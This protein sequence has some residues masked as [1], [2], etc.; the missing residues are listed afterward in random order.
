MPISPES[1][2]AWVAAHTPKTRYAGHHDK[3]VVGDEVDIRERLT[4]LAVLD[5]QS[6]HALLTS[7]PFRWVRDDATNHWSKEDI[8]PSQLFSELMQVPAMKKSVNSKQEW[9][10]YF[11]KLVPDKSAFA[12]QNPLVVAD[13]T[14]RVQLITIFAWVQYFTR[15]LQ[16]MQEDEEDAA[17][18][19]EV[20]LNDARGSKKKG[21][22]ATTE[23]ETTEKRK[24]DAAAAAAAAA[25]AKDAEKKRK[26]DAAAAAAAAALTA[27]ADEMK[28]HPEE[29]D[30]GEEGAGGSDEE[31]EEQELEANPLEPGRA[32]EG[33]VSEK[34]AADQLETMKALQEASQAL[35]LSHTSIAGANRDSDLQIAR[36]EKLATDVQKLGQ[37]LAAV[38]KVTQTK[39]PPVS[40]AQDLKLLQEQV[41]A[42]KKKS[43][44]L[45][46]KNAGL[47]Q[48]LLKV[49]AQLAQAVE[50]GGSHAKAMEKLQGELEAARQKCV[51]LETELNNTPTPQAAPIT[52]DW[53]K[54]V[55]V[56]EA[57]IKEHGK[58]TAGKDATI[59]GLQA[60]L[61]AVK[62]A[63]LLS[64]S[65]LDPQKQSVEESPVYR[66][67]KAEHSI[68]LAE[69]QTIGQARRLAEEEL[70]H[71]RIE[72]LR[73]Q[74]AAKVSID[75]AHRDE[76]DDDLSRAFIT[77]AV[78]T[79]APKKKQSAEAAKELFRHLDL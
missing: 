51:T 12:R 64:Q 76:V 1:V 26:H 59:T 78:I 66:N 29:E 79:R 47:E 28:A 38:Q 14:T 16:L 72:I 31:Q 53:L 4:I 20:A 34:A 30:S 21:T 36:L 18:Q 62:E 43:D 40:Q 44:K 69:L 3:T 37:Q 57:E 32:D 9:A 50:P 41:N 48:Q 77:R 61:L 73:L 33:A 60:E 45:E 65:P 2:A 68:A 74:S 46:G 54:R 23:K 25:K 52:A 15:L 5:P 55:K 70:G 10:G 35:L 19:L 27:A 39:P 56:M 49:K 11:K 67:L 8:T 75:S 17:K 63:L 71:A 22:A 7:L 58:E 6:P 42:E 13:P 24:Q